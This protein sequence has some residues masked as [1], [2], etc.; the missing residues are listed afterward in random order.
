MIIIVYLYNIIYIYNY[1]I[2]KE[3]IPPNKQRADFG[4]IVQTVLVLYRE[5]DVEKALGIDL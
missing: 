5:V 3:D 1:K 4:G 2:V